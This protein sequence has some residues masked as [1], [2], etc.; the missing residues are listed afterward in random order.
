MSCV[1]VCVCVCV[2][3]IYICKYIY[4]FLHLSQNSMSFVCVCVCVCVYVCVCVW[5]IYMCKYIYCFLHVNH[6]SKKYFFKKTIFQTVIW[7]GT[8]SAHTFSN[9]LLSD[10]YCAGWGRVSSIPTGG[11]GGRLE[12]LWSYPVF[13]DE[14]VP[15][16]IK[17]QCVKV[18][19][20]KH[21]GVVIIKAIDFNVWQAHLV[22]WEDGVWI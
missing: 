17:Y 22:V 13:V 2:C 18:F 7:N 20:I 12:V 21:Q 11:W 3:G 14:K 16:S 19:W 4:C 6:N 1:C 5:C 8:T 9:N 15:S 10:I